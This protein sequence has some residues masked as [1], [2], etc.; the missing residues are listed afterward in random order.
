MF[1]SY[2]LAIYGVFFPSLLPLFLCPQRDKF[3]FSLYHGRP[4]HVWK[5]CQP[6]SHS[7]LP[8]FFTLRYRHICLQLFFPSPETTSRPHPLPFFLF[9]A[10]SSWYVSFLI[11][12]VV[13]PGV[14]PRCAPQKEGVLRLLCGDQLPTP[15]PFPF[16][17]P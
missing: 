6:R 1:E 2:Q 7:H 5:L 8:H 11:G 9:S 10:I 15:P 12:F 16:T 3:P 14:S 17:G 13:P 4:S